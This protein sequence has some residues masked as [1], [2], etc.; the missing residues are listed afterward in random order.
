VLPA[1]P[2]PPEDPA[3]PPVC[4]ISAAIS[5]PLGCLTDDVGPGAAP[6]LLQW[7]AILLTLD[8]SKAFATPEELLPLLGML[9]LDSLVPVGTLFPLMVGLVADVGV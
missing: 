8:T 7:S 2:A 3:E 4:G 1:V 5:T 6:G 9:E